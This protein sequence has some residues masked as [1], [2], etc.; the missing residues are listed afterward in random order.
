MEGILDGYTGIVHGLKTA[1]KSVPGAID[2]F[3]NPVALQQGCLVLVQAIASDEDKSEE[4]LKTLS[5]L[6]PLQPPHPP[7]LSAQ[8]L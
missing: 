1:T 3:L 8:T 4:V 5:P 6:S 7:K 2:A